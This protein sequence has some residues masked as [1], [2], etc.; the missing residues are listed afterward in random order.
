MQKWYEIKAGSPTHFVKK[1]VGN[2]T[3][4]NLILEL[5][6][7]EFFKAWP[8]INIEVLIFTFTPISRHLLRHDSAGDLVSGL[9]HLCF[10]GKDLIVIKTIIVFVDNIIVIN[11]IIIRTTS[12]SS[13]WSLS[14]TSS[15]SSSLHHRLNCQFDHCHHL[16]IVKQRWS[17]AVE[18]I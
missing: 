11:M 16:I 7:T 6:L 5:A 18:R 1:R 17:S 12:L 4:C 3:R 15:S 13:I 10:P 9:H 14:E 8:K 2:L